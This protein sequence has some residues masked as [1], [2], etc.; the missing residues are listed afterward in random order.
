MIGGT[1]RRFDSCESTND[2]AAK[3][4]KQ[5]HD[6][7][8]HGGVIVADSQRAGRGRLGRQWHSPP[9]SNLYFSVVLRLA[10]PPDKVPPIT[11]CAGLAVCE[12]VNT[13][14]AVASIKWPNDIYVGKNKL[15]GVLTE[16]STQSQGTVSEG[17]SSPVESTVI[18]GIGVNVNGSA[19]PP[20]LAAT[21]LALECGE[22][23]DRAILLGDILSSMHQWVERYCAHGVSALQRAFEGHSMLSGQL[24][25]AKIGGQLRSG[26]VVSLSDDGALRLRDSAGIEHK[27]I[28]GEI[29]CLGEECDE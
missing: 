11:L 25:R 24:V 23:I 5:I 17:Q 8:P 3:W 12:V 20:E 26:K 16:M 1:I 7:A 29:E 28:A 14:G 18:V 6:R 19:F 13:R 21:S 22:T 2:E 27:I 9:G 4:A 15:A 10:L